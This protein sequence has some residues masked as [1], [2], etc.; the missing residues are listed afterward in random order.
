M[1]TFAPSKAPTVPTALNVERRFPLDLRQSDH[2]IRALYEEAKAGHWIPNTDLPWDTFDANAFDAGQ[3]SA[4]ARVWSRRAWIEYTG[5]AE[6]PAL[7]I[8]F[9]IE[10]ERESDPKYFLTVR[11]TEEAWHVESFWR[12]AEL[13]GGY[14]ESPEN[15]H[16]MPLFN[17]NLYRD[18]LD[19]SRS[20]DAHVLT[21]C[22]FVD[23]L[24]SA[25]TT[26]WLANTREPVAK[27]LLTH[28]AA[29]RERHARFGKLYMKRRAARMSG[30]ERE[31]AV[32]ALVQHLQEVELAGM[33]C[34][35]LASAID[36][37]KEVAENDAVARVGMGSIPAQDEVRVF[38]HYLA[39]FR[40][41][42][43]AMNMDL[44]LLQHPTLGEV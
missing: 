40:S 20:L 43:E 38:Q 37:G 44:P 22:M 24:E 5:I 10:L 6:T 2:A 42:L 15:P 25:L 8:R 7:L 17:R 31:A 41:D 30:A 34:V 1:Q 21:H 39:R 36:A 16:W 13:C 9:C 27:A 14:L 26:A 29:A 4:A 32:Q 35:G 3:R 18:A 11:N 28:C 23:G 33:H 12:Y 19:A